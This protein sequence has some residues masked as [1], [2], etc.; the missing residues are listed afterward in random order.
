MHF[1]DTQPLTIAEVPS[2]DEAIEAFDAHI[3]KYR[4]ALNTEGVWLFLSSLGCWSAPL[5]FGFQLIAFMVAGIVFAH[6]FVASWPDRTTFA[7]TERKLK[8][9]LAQDTT[10]QEETVER[11][12]ARL[13]AVALR[14]TSNTVIVRTGWPFLTC[15]FY[16]GFAF[17]YSISKTALLAIAKLAA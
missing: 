8:A 7:A 13:T 12:K 17:S 10:M 1:E 5:D 14:A 6:R 9:R 4:S 3:T 11:H 15:W 16:W 2:V